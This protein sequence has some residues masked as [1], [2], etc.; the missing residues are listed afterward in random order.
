MTTVSTSAFYDSAIYNMQQLRKDTQQMQAQISTSDKVQHA[1][2]DPVA[3]AQLRTLSLQ[4]TLSGAD[5]ANTN[6]AKT[7]LTQAD[8]TLTQFST[9]LTTIQTKASQAANA[10]LTDTQ[11]AAIGQEIGSYYQN[12]LSLANTK[13]SNGHALFGGQAAGD[14]YTLNA[15]TGALQYNGTGT[16]NTLTLGPGLSV[17]TGVTGPDFLNYTSGGQSVN[18]LDVVKDLADT[19]K[20]GTSNGTAGT[21]A[22][23]TAANAALTTL[24]DGLNTITTAQ[25]IV[26][27]RLSW[28]NTTTTMQSNLKLIREQQQSD[29][30][31]TD[32]TATYAKLQETMTVLEAAQASF[33]KVANLSLFSLLN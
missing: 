27:A 2:D 31:G 29:V 1:Y 28:V 9:I 10:T 20:T 25:T 8:D 33:V 5:T 23:A 19:L 13:D 17:T 6:A 22:L 3:A 21:S 32:I 26:G 24:G 12:L 30:G 11:R 15:T 7:S 14:A 16:A 4:D 18:L